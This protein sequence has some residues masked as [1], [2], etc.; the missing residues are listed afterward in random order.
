MVDDGCPEILQISAG[1]ALVASRCNFAFS[2]SSGGISRAVPDEPSGLM[3]ELSVAGRK[4][5]GDFSKY[6]PFL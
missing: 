3:G 1:T 2:A 4:W 6:G 5:F